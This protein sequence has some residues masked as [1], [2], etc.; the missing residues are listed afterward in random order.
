MNANAERQKKWREAHPEKAAYF[1][2]RRRCRR[3]LPHNRS[4]WRY[5]GRGIEFRFESFE[6]FYAE[7]GP[8]PS[9]LH[10]LDR[11]DNEGHY[12]SGNVRWATSSEQR[13]NQS[14][15]LNITLQDGSPSTDESAA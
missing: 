6:Q 4:W 14:R 1:Q 9:P 2:A 15:R 8:R 7:L 11:I 12:E 3:A 13:L 5:G 10:S